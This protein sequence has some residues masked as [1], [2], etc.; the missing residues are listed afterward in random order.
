VEP[1]PVLAALGYPHAPGLAQA[2]FAFGEAA[3]PEAPAEPDAA[4]LGDPL[5]DLDGEA[6]PLGL[7][8][9]PGAVFE[10]VDGEAAGLPAAVSPAGGCEFIVV[11]RPIPV[12]SNAPTTA[13]ASTPRRPSRRRRGAS[14]S[15]LIGAVRSGSSFAPKPSSGAT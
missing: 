9:A 2:G 14:G 4:A 7:A 13:T 11:A 15:L 5:A 8:P 3:L 6:V 10:P 1:N 12:P